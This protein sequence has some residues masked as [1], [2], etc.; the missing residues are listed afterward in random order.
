MAQ[1]GQWSV[2]YRE[3]FQGRTGSHLQNVSKVPSTIREK[4]KFLRKWRLG[5]QPL[6]CI[7]YHSLG[8]N[9]FIFIEA[10]GQLMY[11]YHTAFIL[12]IL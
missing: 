1:C 9:D 2:S 11:T 12:L 3:H 8:G 10:P 5:R 6:I 7:V 4:E